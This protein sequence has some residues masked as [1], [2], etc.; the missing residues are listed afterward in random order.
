MVAARR[1]A[2]LLLALVGTLGVAFQGWHRRPGGGSAEARDWLQRSLSVAR[3]IDVSAV[4]VAAFGPRMMEAKMRVEQARTGV[5]RHTVLEPAPAAGAV[6]IDDG[7]T[8]W[9]YLPMAKRVFVQESPRR[10]Q[11]L[12]SY[13]LSLASL[14]YQFRMRPGPEIAGRRTVRVVA[15]PRSRELPIRDHFLDRE[16]AYLLRLVVAY[17][18]GTR[19]TQIDTLQVDFDV[20]PDP[21]ALRELPKDASTERMQPPVTLAKPEDARS[22]AGFVPRIPKSLPFGFIVKEIQ[23][24]GPPKRRFVA[25]RLVD[26]LVTATVYQ[27][28]PAPNRK[29]W[30]YDMPFFREAEGVRMALLGD[31]PKPVSD[32]LLDA[33]VR[34]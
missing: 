28:A 1:L 7:R 17:P 30:P 23:L 3:A 27:W 5:T 32:A 6:T 9:S 10:H 8:W 19:K 2:L 15:L 22:A 14:N 4:V 11:D 24:V 33:F 12:P 20:R 25:V 34:G 18:D 21:K 13:Q 29:G 31:V 16:T 26:G